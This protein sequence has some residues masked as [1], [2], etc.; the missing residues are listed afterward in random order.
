[1]TVFLIHKLWINY[2]NQWVEAK[3]FT[4]FFLLTNQLTPWSR[5]LPEKLKCPQL[6][7]KFPAF[8]GTRKFITVYTRARHLSL[9]W[10]TSTQS[11]PPHPTSQR[12][13]L[14]LSSHLRLGL[15]SGLLH[16]GFPTKALYASLLSPIRATCP[17]HLSILD[18]ITRI[19]FF[20]LLPIP[21][22]PK[23]WCKHAGTKP[24]TTHVLFTKFNN[25]SLIDFVKTLVIRCSGREL[26][27]FEISR[28]P[29]N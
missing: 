24:V 9:S 15:P 18:L 13:I 17:A 1:M 23:K 21:K 8:Y 26:G 16:S 27:A 14:I 28:W 3:Y 22:C 4:I 7:K 29:Q 25:A 10:A 11:A 12:S 6:L 2:S 20:F 19:I 5:V